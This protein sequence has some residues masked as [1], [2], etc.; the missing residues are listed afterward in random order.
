M[1]RKASPR[2]RQ[3][4]GALR[5]PRAASSDR[6]SGGMPSPPSAR[7]RRDLAFFGLLLLLLVI[8]NLNFR[9][10]HSIDTF[11]ARFLPFSLLLDHSLYLDRWIP[12][13][14]AAT[15]GVHGSHFAVKSHGHFV[16]MYPIITP[17]VVTPLYVLPAWW[18]SRQSPPPDP[19][20]PVFTVIVST[21][22]KLSASL[23]AAMSGAVLFLAFRKIAPRYVSVVV[24][25][26]Y[27]LTSNTWA[28]SSQGLWRHGLTELSFAF[29]LWA[30]FRV[31]GSP[32]APFWAGLALAAAAANKPLDAILIVPFLLYFARRPWKNGLLF[33]TPLVAVGSLVFAYNLYF[34]ARLLGGYP[35]PM[36]GGEG[37]GHFP[38]LARVVVGLPGSLVSPSRGLLVFT[39]WTAFTFWGAARLWKEKSLGWSRALIVALVA[40]CVVQ[41]GGGDWWGGWCFGPR[42]MTDLLPFLAWFLVLVWGSIRARPVLRVAFAATVAIALWVQV[43]GAFYY[44]AGD[45][46]G[47]PVNVN[48]EPQRLWDWSDNQVLRSWRAGPAV[49]SLLI[50]W[51]RLLRPRSGVPQP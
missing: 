37:G 22:E 15:L 19:F 36:L 31:P 14:L 40:V 38:F 20:S 4:K 2:N 26:I 42:Y 10:I 24:A 28:I 46:D 43:V 34:F 9:T 33:L 51:E 35:A 25:L 39:P 17:V 29:L 47:S 32:S 44:P 30:L 7:P 49:P 41:A 18:F 21:M 12:P 23:I 45:W 8:Y 16:S 5:R 48:F 11:P 27:G 1:A 3:R 6:L 13:P 50:Q